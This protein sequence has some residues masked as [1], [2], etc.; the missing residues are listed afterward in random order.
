MLEAL[1]FKLLDKSGKEINGCGENLAK[2]N[3][4]TPPDEL[5][6]VRF[7]I[8]SDVTNPLLGENGA[9]KV[10]GPQKGATPNMVEKL[11]NGLRNWGNILEKHCQKKIVHING[12]GAAGGIALPLIAFL[13]AELV[14]GAGFILKLLDFEKH[15]SWAD[16]VITGEGKIDGQTLNTKA[17]MAVANHARKA[18]KPVFAIGGSIDFEASDLFDGIFSIV[19]EPMQLSEAVANSKYLLEQTAIQ[20]AKLILKLRLIK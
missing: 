4:I 6:K 18:D 20:L 11:E 1:G 17:P 12:S 8:I 7:K 15:V 3:S 16:V 19:N 2:I 13:N 9:A 5:R 14:Q 10:F